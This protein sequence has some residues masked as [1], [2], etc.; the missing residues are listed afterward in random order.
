MSPTCLR[1]HKP[2]ADPSRHSPF[3]ANQ[4]T[5]ALDGPCARPSDTHPTCLPL[6]RAS[7]QSPCPARTR[8]TTAPMHSLCACRTRCCSTR[9]HWRRRRR[10]RIWL[11]CDH[12]S[13]RNRAQ[14]PCRDVGCRRFGRRKRKADA[15]GTTAVPFIVLH[16]EGSA[17]GDELLDHGRVAVRRGPDERS[18]P[19]EKSVAGLNGVRPMQSAQWPYPSLF[20]TSRAAPAAMSSSTTGVWPF[21]AA[22]MSAVSLPRCQLPG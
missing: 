9:L 3:Q 17:G 14:C 5:A 19:A 21:I 7:P 22:E 15:V 20:C 2:G 8:A 18:A 10:G 12:L 11:R 6:R 13:P 1:G 16:I 4:S